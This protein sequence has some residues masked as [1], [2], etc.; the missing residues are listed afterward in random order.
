MFLFFSCVE[1]I[2]P[3]AVQDC[4]EEQANGCRVEEECLIHV[5]C[6]VNISNSLDGSS[7]FLVLVVVGFVILFCFKHGLVEQCLTL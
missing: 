5:E 4:G 2:T 1:L 6:S 3:A 7:V